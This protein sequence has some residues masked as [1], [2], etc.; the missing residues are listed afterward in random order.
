MSHRDPSKIQLIVNSCLTYKNMMENFPLLC[1]VMSYWIA[2][3]IILP[4]AYVRNVGSLTLGHLDISLLLLFTLLCGCSV[5]QSCQTLCDPMDC[6]MPGFP[7]LHYL[8]KLAQT[9]GHWVYDA[10]QPSHPLSSPSPPAFNLPSIRVFSNE[11]ELFTSGGQS[12]LVSLIK[13]PIL[14][15]MFFFFYLPVILC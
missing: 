15:K 10:I 3:T 12:P 2:S 11:S 4:V 8:L 1:C 14:I 7:V 9:H 6:S 13:S 5:T